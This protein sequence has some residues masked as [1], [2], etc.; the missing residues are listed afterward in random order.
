[1]PTFSRAASKPI[2]DVS[3][4]RFED[5]TRFNRRL[6]DEDN[7]E[8]RIGSRVRPKNRL[9]AK[10]FGIEVTFSPDLWGRTTTYKVW[11]RTARA[12]DQGL[13][14]FNRRENLTAET[15]GWPYRYSAVG[16]I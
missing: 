10:K 12:R 7:E 5:R 8:A 16:I 11:Y 6:D 2:F 14:H 15:C 13:D 4:S 1:M 9:G 3:G